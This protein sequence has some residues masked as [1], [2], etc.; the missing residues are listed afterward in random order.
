M[1]DHFLVRFLVPQFALG[2]VMAVVFLATLWSLS[3]S[4]FV[5]MAAEAHCLWP[6]V[7]ATL[8]GAIFP[9]GV[10]FAATALELLAASDDHRGAE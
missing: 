10:A 9:F 3:S 2:G 8:A 7:L 6:L 4:D 1:P 5:A